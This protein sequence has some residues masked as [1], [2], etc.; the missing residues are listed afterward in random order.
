MMD[1]ITPEDLGPILGNLFEV[2]NIE[3]FSETLRLLH[4]EFLRITLRP[5]AAEPIAHVELIRLHSIANALAAHYTNPFAEERAMELPSEEQTD[6]R[7]LQDGRGLAATIFEYLADYRSL[8]T[9]LSGDGASLRSHRAVDGLPSAARLYVKAGLMYALGSYEAR[10]VVLLKRLAERFDPAEL[11]LED[12]PDRLADWY[13]INLLAGQNR[14]V[15]DARQSDFRA[16]AFQRERSIKLLD[17]DADGDTFETSTRRII[18][19]DLIAGS[20][21]TARAFLLGDEQSLVIGRQR[22][23]QAVEFAGLLRE[24]ETI[25]TISIASK[26]I[27]R[28]W[29]NSPWVRLAGII[30][31]RAYLRSLS[32]GGISTLWTSQLAALD[33]T[34]SLPD[35]NGGYLDDRLRRIVLTM[36]TSAGKTLLCELAI[37][38][39]LIDTPN[40]RCV[41]VA[42]TRALCDQ[43]ATRLRDALAPMGI[44]VAAPVTDNDQVSY[45]T[46]IYQEVNVIVVTPEK[47]SYLFR[48]SSSAARAALF[49]FDEVHMISKP[50]RGWTYE[51]IITLLLTDERTK[52]AKMM[53][54]SAVMPNH[55]AF[56]RWVDPDGVAQSVSSDWQPTRVLKGALVFA[57]PKLAPAEM[58]TTIQGDIVYVRSSAELSSPLRIRG[59]V[60]SNQTL[61]WQ[62]APAG[63]AYKKRVPMLSDGYIEHAAQLAVSFSR[64]GPVLVFAPRRSSAEQIAAK[65]ATLREAQPQREGTEAQRDAVEFISEQ[66]TPEH[67]LI[68]MLRH[69]VAYHHGNLTREVRNEVEYLFQSRFADILAVTQT[70]VDGVNFPVKTLVIADYCSSRNFNKE[71]N[72]TILTNA[73]DKRDFRNMVG[74]AGRA[75]A[76]T[77]GQVIVAQSVDDFPFALE[78]DFAEY[79]DVDGSG[80][81]LAITSSLEQDNAIGLLKELVEA[82]DA[83]HLDPEKIVLE[84]KALPSRLKRLTV[85]MRKLSVLA[86][87]LEAGDVSAD[88]AAGQF[89][90]M[91][92]QTFI[93]LQQRDADATECLIDF[94]RHVSRATA[95]KIS[96]VL[97][98]LFSRTGLPLSICFRLHAATRKFWKSHLAEPAVLDGPLNAELIREIA[99]LI[100][101][102][103]DSGGLGPARVKPRTA[104]EGSRS[105]VNLDDPDELL[106]TWMTTGNPLTVREQHF[107]FCETDELKA[108]GFSDYLQQTLNFGTPW[109]LSAF[110]IFSREICA[111]V[112]I[113]LSNTELGRDLMLFPAYAKFGTLNP[114]VAFLSTLG[115]GPNRVARLLAEQFV[116]ENP[117]A[118]R[119][120]FTA[121]FAWI[122]RLEPEKMLSYNIERASVRRIVERLSGLNVVPLPPEDTWG[123]TFRIAGWQ[124]YDGERAGNDIHA[125]LRLYLRAE[126]DNVYDPNAIGIFMTD[127]RRLGYVP[128]SLAVEIGRSLLPTDVAEII[129]IRDTINPSDRVEVR[130]VRGRDGAG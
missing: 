23:A 128:R 96:P 95:A 20:V 116:A 29:R 58:A 74:R 22:M 67:R 10:M 102:A 11:S 73:L 89:G 68:G 31:N 103:G 61:Q 98:A 18:S 86:I 123:F 66:L 14:R 125:G 56:R 120:E 46:L 8:S 94:A 5:G 52:A 50:D 16:I 80:P 92:S 113:E 1:I 33:I 91:L 84:T 54:V 40:R 51:E 72:K 114:F 27:E 17:T 75:F 127:G 44:R 110:W 82:F 36:P 88:E 2:G 81:E 76:E 130:L 47:L 57:T 105:G 34:S 60:E 119:H 3:R 38:K 106:V 15:R 101:K 97:K 32:N 115:I 12:T 24:P 62:R 4:H 28:M 122:T 13:V 35:L 41:Y 55:L 37:V 19:L 25:W 118:G 59:I 83:E 117:L 45:E 121:M 64:L 63:Y 21:A 26:I 71:Q 107:Q 124:Y 49:I 78:R 129:A 65:A 112:P 79:L 9:P 42:P 87:L 69:G 126:P 48:Q 109:L 43:V 53:F 39:A 108:A 99:S 77:E 70:L 6:P 104:G 85:L 100:Y 30:N 7:V 93:A 90:S 111:T